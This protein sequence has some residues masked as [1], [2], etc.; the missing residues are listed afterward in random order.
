MRLLEKN[1]IEIFK[2]NFNSCLQIKV[3]LFIK[4]IFYNKDDCVSKKHNIKVGYFYP[5]RVAPWGHITHL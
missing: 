4:K 3:L 2:R 5:N 1:I